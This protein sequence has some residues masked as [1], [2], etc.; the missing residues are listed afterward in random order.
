MSGLLGRFPTT[1]FPSFWP[2]LLH[3]RCTFWL[4]GGSVLVSS[5]NVWC[6]FLRLLGS[7]VLQSRVVSSPIALPA[8]CPAC[9]A[10]FAST[11]ASFSAPLVD[12]SFLLFGSKPLLVSL[13][14]YIDAAV[15][16]APCTSSCAYLLKRAL[17]TL[18]LRGRPLGAR[19]ER[20]QADYG[21][22]P[23]DAGIRDDLGRGEAEDA[24]EGNPEKGVA[25]GAQ[26]H[27]RYGSTTDAVDLPEAFVAL[28][29]TFVDR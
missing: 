1:L 22:N 19:P 14:A 18:E 16:A 25:G 17:D 20:R 4:C 9:P 7:S 12:L 11:I 26:D 21:T 29:K 27:V 2:G 28:F 5:R 23:T 6:C 24:G 10:T 3:T 15:S 8:A 13:Y